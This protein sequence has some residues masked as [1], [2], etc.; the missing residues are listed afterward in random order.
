MLEIE[1]PFQLC[2]EEFRQNCVYQDVKCSACKGFDSTNSVLHYRPVIK[3]EELS[4]KKHPATLETTAQKNKEKKEAK[5]THR[6]SASFKTAQKNVRQGRKI[7]AKVLAKSNASLTKG[8]GAVY[9]DGD[10][11]ITL[12]GDTKL[13]IEHKAR[14]AGKNVLG[15]T[16]DEWLKA[17]TQGVNIFM[18]TS[19]EMGTIV[20]MTQQ[21]LNELLSLI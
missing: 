17:A 19:S 9:G 12:P 8:S 5:K 11:F 7:E 6:A 3:D 4:F 21:T 13:Y 15:P 18:T 10:G 1:E 20:T 14:L 16:K 2:P